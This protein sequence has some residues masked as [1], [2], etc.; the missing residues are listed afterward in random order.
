LKRIIAL[1]AAFL[2]A[3]SS[4]AQVDPN[5][6]V[7]TING[8]EIKGA[9]YYHR[10][11]YLGGVFKVFGR[12]PLNYPPGFFTIEQLVTEHLILQ[13]AAHRGLAPTDQEVQQR[14]QDEL[15]DDPN[16]LNDWLAT[17]LTKDD[18]IASV[19]VKVAQFKLATEGITVTD[20]EI[21]NMYKDNPSTYTIPKRYKL[22][23]IVV[24]DSNAQTLVDQDLATG[25]SFQDVAKARSQDISSQKGGE[26]GT[27]AESVIPD[28]TL[29]ALAGV[30]IGQTTDW[31]TT[32]E[33]GALAK[34]LVEDILK[35]ELMPLDAKLRRHI[36][37]ETMLQRGAARNDLGKEMLDMRLNAKIDIKQKEFAD[38]Y[39]KF[40]AAY[41]KQQEAA[42]SPIAPPAGAA[43]AAGQ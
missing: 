24:S 12:T 38:S 17:G 30:K 18:Y 23:I 1:A 29:K 13:L 36:R 20:Q 14:M 6:V 9:E 3:L 32:S 28:V 25:K 35:P 22:R 15:D 42:A 40:I 39:G 34:Y 43:P 27:W 4:Y 33:K 41:L 8:E 7:L 26:F 31:T 2:V 11:E 10:M 5:R 16:V 19:A 21:D 37:T